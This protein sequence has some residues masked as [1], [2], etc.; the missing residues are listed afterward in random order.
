MKQNRNRNAR[1]TGHNRTT[2]I[3]RTEQKQNFREE[4]QNRNRT[5]GNSE[6]PLRTVSEQSG[7]AENRNRMEQNSEKQRRTK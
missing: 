6:E 2:D 7:T 3:T 5:A 1:T 4:K